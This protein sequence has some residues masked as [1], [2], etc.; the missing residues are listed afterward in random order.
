MNNSASVFAFT[1]V[2]K[3]SADNPSLASIREMVA[4]WGL[5]SPY[6][7]DNMDAWHVM[8]HVTNN[9]DLATAQS[10]DTHRID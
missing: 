1:L 7:V 10:V 4:T 3:F 5:S 8:L 2:L 9:E 6:R